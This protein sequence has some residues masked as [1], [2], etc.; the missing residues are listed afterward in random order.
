MVKISIDKRF[1]FRFSVVLTAV[2]FV[3][4]G[5][6]FYQLSKIAITV[7]KSKVKVAE[8]NRD[9]VLLDRIV[10]DRK[11]YGGDISKI[12]FTLPSEYYE[13]SFFSQQLERLAQNNNLI[14][15]IKIEQNKKEEKEPFDSIAYAV[16]LSGSYSNVSEFLSQLAKLPYHTSVDL[17]KM[18]LE[19]GE[20]AT[21][22][23]FRLFVEK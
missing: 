23:K 7:K 11:Q 22:V 2:S 13:V 9:L 20:L 10:E 3:L 15:N 17:V 14:L 5:V 21:D 12:K 18:N 19:E 16:N 1:K 8:I 6:G 4:I